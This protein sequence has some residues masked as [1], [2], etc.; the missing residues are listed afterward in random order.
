MISQNKFG[1]TVP[2]GNFLTDELS[3]PYCSDRVI[4]LFV[5]E[6][7]SSNLRAMENEPIEG[8]YVELN[9]RNDR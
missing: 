5:R 7:I 8:L 1:D 4:I 3:I 2:I 6:D 9:L